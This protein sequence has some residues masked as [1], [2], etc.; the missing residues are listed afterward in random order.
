MSATT[1]KLAKRKKKVRR[2]VLAVG[3]PWFYTAWAGTF[4]R[5]A[6][7]KERNGHAIRLRVPAGIG[8]W[9]KVRLV[10]EIVE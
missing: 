2:I 7:T 9:N 5:V 4:D 10:L 8:N 3:H 6:I 1:L